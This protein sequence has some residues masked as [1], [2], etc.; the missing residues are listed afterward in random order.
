MELVYYEIG[1][2]ALLVSC[3]ETLRVKLE[4][5]QHA[6]DYA[7]NQ[8]VQTSMIQ[9]ARRIGTQ[10]ISSRKYDGLVNVEGGFQLTTVYVECK[11][12][13][14]L[15]ARA[16]S[17][18]SQQSKDRLRDAEENLHAAERGRQRTAEGLAL[19]IN[20]L[21]AEDPPQGY[22]FVLRSAG[23]IIECEVSDSVIRWLNSHR[24]AKLLKR[25]GTTNIA[26]IAGLVTLVSLACILLGDPGSG[27]SP[28]KTQGA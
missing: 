7:E 8:V 25:V 12:E 20:R 18:F 10:G 3:L 27:E 6:L 4:E 13:I 15:Y 17:S 16:T 5:A 21:E 14:R 2:R 24:V 28:P 11:M 26:V 9:L 22:R 23:G 1:Y 19:A